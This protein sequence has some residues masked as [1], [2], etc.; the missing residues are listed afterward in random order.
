M[1]Y[2][3]FCH[4]SIDIAILSKMFKIHWVDIN[5]I[6][7]A[8]LNLPP[9]KDRCCFVVESDEVESYLSIY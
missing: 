4:Q 9:S 6:F 1:E 8:Q 7:F 3:D 5:V 2:I